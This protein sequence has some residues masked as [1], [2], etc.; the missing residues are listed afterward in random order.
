[1]TEKQDKCRFEKVCPRHAAGLCKEE[2]Q[3]VA[4]FNKAKAKEEK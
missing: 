1:M 4:A 2:D 3:I